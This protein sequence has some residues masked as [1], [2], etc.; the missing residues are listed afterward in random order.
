MESSVDSATVINDPLSLLI[1][2]EKAYQT[3]LP[4]IDSLVQEDTVSTQ[5]FLQQLPKM[6]AEHKEQAP[7]FPLAESFFH[8]SALNRVKNP[9]LRHIFET[10]AADSLSK[11]FYEHTDELVSFTS[12]G[13]GHCFS[14]LMILTKALMNKPDAHLHIHII[15]SLYT[16]PVKTRKFLHIGQQVS[17]DFNIQDYIEHILPLKYDNAPLSKNSAY[18]IVKPE[19]TVSALLSQLCQQFPQAQ[20]SLFM[21]SST[22]NYLW[23]LKDHHLPHAHVITAADIKDY[24]SFGYDAES[25]GD[26]RLL[27]RVT[28]FRN[29]SS[30]NIWLDHNGRKIGGYSSLDPDK[31]KYNGR[32]ISYNKTFYTKENAVILSTYSIAQIKEKPQNIPH[33]KLNPPRIHLS[34]TT[35]ELLKL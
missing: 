14:T 4:Q 28:L 31:P 2:L 8:L 22:Y 19:Y 25:E 29:P 11:A 33:S 10:R 3:F 26:Y 32:P 5:S 15:D 23:Y 20:L 9:A 34:T 1:S 7:L 24:D 27:C 21:H 16:L 12:F 13:S 17:V 18:S 30:T 35:E 6:V